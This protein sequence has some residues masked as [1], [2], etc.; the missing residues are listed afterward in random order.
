MRQPTVAEQGEL[1][2]IQELVRE[3]KIGDALKRAQ[4]LA[5]AHADLAEAQFVAAE[6]AYRMRRFPDAVAYFRRGGDPGDA[7]PLL[8]FYEAV[9][10]YEAGDPASAAVV[11]KRSLPNIQR[12]PFVEGYIQKILIPD[13]G[14]APKR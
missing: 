9:S 7:R 6:L 3:G 12:T 10:L 11:L 5:D 2:A 8:L 13:A 4:R 14:S 1:D